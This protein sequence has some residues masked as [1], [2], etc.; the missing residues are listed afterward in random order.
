[1]HNQGNQELL[2]LDPEIERTFLARRREQQGLA[3]V[4][5]IAEGVAVNMANDGQ[6]VNVNNLV[7]QPVLVDD[8]DRVIRE[9][10]EF[11]V[12]GDTP[13]IH[14]NLRL[15]DCYL[16]ISAAKS[17]ALQLPISSLPLVQWAST[18]FGIADSSCE[19]TQD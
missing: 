4:G 19:A 1:M 15:N 3:G 14:R 11:P 16:D 18:L 13:A 10:A 8:R 12:S 7:P 2:P 9:Y 6:Q 5:E 17:D